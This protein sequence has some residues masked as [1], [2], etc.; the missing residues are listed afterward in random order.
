MYIVI[1][2]KGPQNFYLKMLSNLLQRWK[3]FSLSPITLWQTD[4]WGWFPLGNDNNLKNSKHALDDGKRETAEASLLL[5]P[6]PIFPCARSF[7]PLPSLPM[8]KRNLCG[9]GRW[10]VTLQSFYFT[11][12]RVYT[13]C[14]SICMLF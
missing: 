1:S 10:G 4:L 2:W 14:Y 7:F 8:T 6:L 11:K 13:T 3:T 9:G 5:F 12:Q